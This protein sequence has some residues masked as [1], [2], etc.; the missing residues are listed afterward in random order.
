M[1]VAHRPELILTTH[2]E[3]SINYIILTEV[4]RITLYIYKCNV[5]I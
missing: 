3:I 5:G 4:S 1:S 2:M